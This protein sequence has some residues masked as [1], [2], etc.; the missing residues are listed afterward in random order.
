MSEE[1]L[2]QQTWL[3]FIWAV[4]SQLPTRIFMLG[5]SHV[6]VEHKQQI[7]QIKKLLRLLKFLDL[8]KS[9]NPT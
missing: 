8:H 4:R 2:H 7:Y 9:L 1:V 6:K 3:T 5:R